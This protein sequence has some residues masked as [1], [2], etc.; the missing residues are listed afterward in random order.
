MPRI[1]FT[2]VEVSTVEN[3]PRC[4]SRAF[5]VTTPRI[6][7]LFRANSHEFA[8]TPH[9]YP[10]FRLA[11]QNQFW[12]KGVLGFCTARPRLGAPCNASSR[13]QKLKR[14]HALTRQLSTI[15]RGARMTDTQSVVCFFDKRPGSRDPGFIRKMLSEER[16]RRERSRPREELEG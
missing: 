3:P 7:P 16:S 11:L 1:L 5:P 14:V 10:E 12:V 8:K 6:S 9:K 4:D 15:G 2:H 13:D